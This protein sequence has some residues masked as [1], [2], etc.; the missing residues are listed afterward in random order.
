PKIAGGCHDRTA[1]D[2]M[3]LDHRDH[4]LWRLA[5]RRLKLLGD[6]VVAQRRLGRGQLLPKLTNVGTRYED[7][8]ARTRKHHDPHRTVACQVSDLLCEPLHDLEIE[9]ITHLRT[10][11]SQPRYRAVSLDDE[12]A[13]HLGSLWGG[14]R[15]P[16][17]LQSH[18]TA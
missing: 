10:I 4:R 11:H 14:V 3:A 15:T 5:Q 9:C 6:R 13:I 8:V 12:F 17:T 16:H 2:R 1:P 7:T 18:L